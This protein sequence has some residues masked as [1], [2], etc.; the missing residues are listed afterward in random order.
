MKGER[1]PK[2]VV[3]SLIVV[4]VVLLGFILYTFAVRPAVTGYVANE[5]YRGYQAAILS[6]IQEAVQCKQVPLVFGNQTINLIAVECLQQTA[7][8]PQQ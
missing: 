5:Q 6:I 2:F 1:N 4:I 8:Q 3:I 7:S